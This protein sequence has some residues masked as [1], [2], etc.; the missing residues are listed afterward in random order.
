MRYASFSHAGRSSFGAMVSETVLADLGCAAVP[1]LAT[2]LAGNMPDPADAPR[3]NLSDVTLLPVI[4][5]PSKIF[6]VGHNYEE[7]RLET[8]GPR[9]GHPSI[10]TRFADT[11]VA[12]DAPVIRPHVSTMLDYEGEFALVIGKAGR[13]ISERDAM[14]HIAGYSCANDATVRDWQRHTSQFTPGKNF[15][16]TGGLGPWLVTPDEVS[17][18]DA[19]TLTT[20]LNGE[21]MQHATLAQL[22]FSVPTIIAYLSAFTKLEAGDVIMTGTPGGVGAKREPPVWMQTGDHV[23]VE[24]SGVGILCNPIVA[25][26]PQCGQDCPVNDTNLC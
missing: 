15:P 18:L 26:L 20:R 2:A 19:V 17:D 24:I 14:S 4:P 9:V 10:F 21:V 8:N 1:D 3:L 12:H 16:S 23:T 22:I 13:H 11:L 6:C 25:E 7:H 5:R